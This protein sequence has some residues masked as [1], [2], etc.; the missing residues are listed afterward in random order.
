MVIAELTEDGVFRF[1][2][3][4]TTENAERFITMIEEFLQRRVTAIDVTKAE[5]ATL[6][7]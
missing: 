3:D 1:K 6:P 2:V 5:P 7:V 4:A